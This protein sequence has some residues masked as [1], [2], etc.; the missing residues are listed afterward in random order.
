MPRE[1]IDTSFRKLRSAE[2]AFELLQN[3]KSIKSKG[4]IQRQMMN[5]VNDILQQ[6]SREI[7]HTAQIFRVH[8]DSP[9]LTRNQPPVAGA[10]KWSRSL[11]ARA[12]QTMNKLMGVE[13]DIRGDQAGQ[14]VHDKY[15]SFA[16]E[17]MKYE[18]QQFCSWSENADGIAM[19]NLKKPIL[20][21]NS[22]TGKM[23]ESRSALNDSRL[24]FD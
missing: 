13:A 4:A 24:M 11:F 12:K 9:P 17:V 21:N 19:H 8:R 23:S 6:F 14:Q 18:K 7:D 16:R 20:A 22:E 3:F 10:I 2:A 5:K 1:L 15:L